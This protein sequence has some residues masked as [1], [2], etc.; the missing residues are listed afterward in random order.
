MEHAGFN[1]NILD[2]PLPCEKSI[3]DNRIRMPLK[4]GG[5]KKTNGYQQKQALKNDKVAQH[6]PAQC[7][8]DHAWYIYRCIYP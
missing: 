7:L 8:P 2:F 1:V 4:I 3:E 5:E 6:V